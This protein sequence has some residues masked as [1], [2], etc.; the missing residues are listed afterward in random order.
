MKVTRKTTSLMKS[1][2]YT[3]QAEK[4]EPQMVKMAIYQK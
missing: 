3:A 4:E 2:R 1:E